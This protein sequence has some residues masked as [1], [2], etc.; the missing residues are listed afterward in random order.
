MAVPE[1]KQSREEKE[2]LQSALIRKGLG[3]FL[4]FD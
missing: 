1:R 3:S 2:R 4:G